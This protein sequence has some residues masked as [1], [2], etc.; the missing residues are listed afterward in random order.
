MGSIRKR[1]ATFRAEVYRRGVR[2]SA[3]FATRVE[4]ADWIVKR[5]A[6]LLDGKPVAATGKTLADAIDHYLGMTDRKRSERARLH[7]MKRHAWAKKPLPLL[8]PADLA[9]WRDDRLREVK[10]ET[11]RREM[12]TL[13]SVLEV[14]RKELQ[15][16]ADNPLRDVKRPPKQPPR[17][18]LISD[19][20]R[21][22][23]V[24]ALKFGGTSVETI[25][26]EV[27]VAFLLALE[28]AMRAGELLALKPA[29]VDY[30]RRVAILHKS[31][32]GPGRDVPLSTRAVELFRVLSDKRLLRR[33]KGTAGGLFHIDGDTL[34]MTFRR[35]RNAAGLSGFTFHDSRATALTRLAKILQPLDLAR[36]SGHSNLSE[37]LTYYRE[38]VESIAVRL[39]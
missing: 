38:P 35:A 2:D 28:T 19:E 11:V 30:G 14:A 29:D 23:M 9:G 16:I 10:I 8:K 34:D 6:E 27:A 24:A 36:M 32:S 20:E 15:W 37:L 22:A 31:K 13:R 33:R 3:T 17:K 4:A 39:G 5:E 12:T 7:V 21:D 18:R 26:H 25:G 1:G